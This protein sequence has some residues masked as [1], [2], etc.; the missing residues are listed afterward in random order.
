MG[1]DKALIRN[2]NV[3]IFIVWRP[4]ILKKNQFFKTVI[5]VFT[6]TAILGISIAGSSEAPDKMVFVPG[7]PFVMGVDKAIN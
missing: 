3:I 6:M 4:K 5:G 2:T 1:V 7:G